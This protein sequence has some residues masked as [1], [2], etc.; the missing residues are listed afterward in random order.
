[1]GPSKPATLTVGKDE[2]LDRMSGYYANTDNYLQSTGQ[3]SNHKNG[4][5]ASIECQQGQSMVQIWC[6]DRWCYDKLYDLKEEGLYYVQVTSAQGC[7]SEMS[8]EFDYN[9]R[10]VNDPVTQTIINVS[11]NPTSG[12]VRIDLQHPTVRKLQS[13][14]SI[15]MC[16][17]DN[18]IVQTEKAQTTKE[19]DMSSLTS[20]TYYIR[21]TCGKNMFYEKVVLTK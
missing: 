17:S 5:S 21:F 15:F 11:P 6:E 13:K 10:S 4:Q 1:V 12:I 9:Y 14:F 16:Q 19:I 8:E 7:I 3:T 2:F 18:S 20:G